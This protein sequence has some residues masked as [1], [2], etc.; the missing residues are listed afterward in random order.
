MK[1]KTTFI[2]LAAGLALSLF[3]NVFVIWSL[4]N[5]R[6]KALST[7]VTARESLEQ[8]A[9]ESFI[10]DVRINQIL[11][12]EMNIEIDQTIS[13]PIDTTYPLNT[14]VHTTVSLPVFGPQDIAVPINEEI[15]LQMNLELPVQLTVPISTEYHLD[16]VL[17]VEISLPRETAGKLG[18]TLQDIEDGLR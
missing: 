2:V 15:P 6:S 17:P 13:V 11:P 18:Q 10:A 5:F 4:F 9:A 1:S 12:L 14:V 3:V 16:T 7:V 8:L